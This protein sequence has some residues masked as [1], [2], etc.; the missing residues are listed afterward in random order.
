MSADCSISKFLS[1]VEMIRHAMSLDQCMQGRHL[2]QD[3]WGVT[4]LQ[5]APASQARKTDNLMD[6]KCSLVAMMSSWKT[7]FLKT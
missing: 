4:T 3:R 7:E 5:Q 6:W 2:L 1:P